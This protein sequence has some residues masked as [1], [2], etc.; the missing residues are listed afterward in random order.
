MH[1]PKEPNIEAISE[2]HSYISW[3]L[4]KVPRKGCREKT[5]SLHTK[6]NP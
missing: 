3:I 6:N 1:G 2:S 5:V 4:T